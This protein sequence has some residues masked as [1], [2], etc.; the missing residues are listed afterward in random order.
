MRRFYNY[1]KKN[2]FLAAVLAA[3]AVIAVFI[4]WLQ[5]LAWAETH[6]T[7]VYKD[8]HKEKTVV[9][10]LDEKNQKNIFIFS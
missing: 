4:L 6:I 9:Q 8:Y 10:S 3:V 1:M 2:R 5:L 7:P